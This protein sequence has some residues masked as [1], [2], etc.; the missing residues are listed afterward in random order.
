MKSILKFSLLAATAAILATGSA[1]ADDQQLQNRLAM[2]RAQDSQTSR[3][4]T[5]VAAYS[6]GRG[7][8]RTVASDER[9]E[10]RFEVRSDAHG[11]QMGVYVPVK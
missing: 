2:Q 9:T 10:T 7:V 11:R 1:L 8:G 3:K 6:N 5:T 4:T